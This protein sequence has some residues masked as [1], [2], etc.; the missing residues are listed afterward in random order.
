MRR[1]E[2]D[3]M[4]VP[5]KP[6]PGSIIGY[7]KDGREI[8]LI[9]GGSEPIGEPA[10]AAPPTPPPVPPAPPAPQPTP[11]P[12]P[13]AFN[14]NSPEAI[15][16]RDAERA[17]IAAEEGAKART[18]SKDAARKELLAQLGI[19][20]EKPEDA[21]AAL[22]AER[23]ERKAERVQNAVER[24]AGKAG[25]DDDLIAAYLAAKGRLKDLDPTAS[26][27]G[28]K[29]KALIDAALVEKPSLKLATTPAAVP[30]GGQG[31]GTSVVPGSTP[32]PGGR[33]TDLVSAYAKH[34]ASK[35]Q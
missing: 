28:D 15:A 7:R 24:A 1:S 35:T 16:W 25:A 3:S 20:A 10:P 21:A 5:L 30:P 27:F 13:P 8:R 14:P 2:G 32:A 34:Y 26:D 9:G 23:A 19:E 22:A 31:P 29:V 18:G 11:V 17:K 6:A 12:A 33:P 4:T